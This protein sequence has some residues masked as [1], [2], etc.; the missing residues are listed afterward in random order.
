MKMWIGLTK[1]TA[2][3]VAGATIGLIAAD[4]ALAGTYG[5][6]TTSVEFVL[7]VF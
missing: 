3:I 6:V 5:F 4:A 7:S 2:A 1:S